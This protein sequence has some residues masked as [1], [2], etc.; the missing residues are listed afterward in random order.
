MGHVLSTPSN[1]TVDTVDI[2][3]SCTDAEKHM[4]ES[5]VF[6]LLNQEASRK[7][8]T[9]SG[10]MQGARIINPKLYKLYFPIISGKH[11]IGCTITPT[12]HQ[13]FKK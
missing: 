2:A 5:L 6:S 7:Q 8:S 12:A 10:R 4:R 13:L 1:M 11:I 9:N 3:H